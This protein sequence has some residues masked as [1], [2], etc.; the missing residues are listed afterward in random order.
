[1]VRR[2]ALVGLLVG[3][4][5]IAAMQARAA[6]GGIA[7]PLQERWEAIRGLV[8][9]TAEVFPEEKYDFKPTPEVR[10]VREQLIHIIGENHMYMGM[11]AGDPPV[12]MNKFNS[13]KTKAEIV[14]A[15][16][17]SYD[18]G[19]KTL[20]GLNDQKAAEMISIRNQPSPRW[21]A[22]LFNIMDNMDHY[23]NLVVY[24]RL[25]GIVPPRTAARQQ[26][27]AR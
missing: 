2:S 4:I 1:M 18:Y 22:A 25:N 15:L 16:K 5:G 8:V 3:M 27:P 9:G 13:L 14:N 6:E 17:A 19:A 21:G 10:T 11:A 7:G 24:M 23:G 26:P 12:D 20:A